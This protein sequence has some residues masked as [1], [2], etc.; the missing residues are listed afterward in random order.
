MHN[1]SMLYVRARL[2]ESDGPHYLAIVKALAQG[3]D[4]GDLR[5]GLP[6]PSQ[7]TLAR[8]LGLHFT[9]VT[10]AYGEAKRRGLISTEPG[11]GTVIAGSSRMSGR[12]RDA[13]VAKVVD[14]SAVWPPTLRIPLDLSAALT[15]LGGEGGV[16]LF[17][18]RTGR[19]ELAVTEPATHWLQPRF[20]AS[21]VG[22]VTVSAGT[23]GALL[24]L[25]RL[26]VGNGGILLTEAMT[27]PT[28]KALASMFDVKLRGVEMDAE[29]I[30]PESLDRHARKS[31]A[32]ALY[33]VPNSQNPTNGIMSLQRRQR[34][35]EVVLRHDLRVFED[36]VYGELMD[37]GL[38]P[39]AELVPSHAYYIA[40]L[41]K[42]LSPTLRVAYVI[43]PEE[44]AARDLESL[45]RSTM[46]LPAPIE[47]ALTI[48]LMQNGSAFRHIAK[49]RA[50]ARMR[51]AVA[52][53]ALGEFRHA[54]TVGP[55]FAWLSLPAQW[56]RASF[57]EGMRR[58]GVLLL[59]SDVFAVDG[60]AAPHCIRIATGSA[61]DQH[62]LRQ[63]FVA[64]AGLLA[65][66]EEL[67]ISGV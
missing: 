61:A 58:R 64:T 21:L 54:A 56:N 37:T 2:A 16:R 3:I 51:R 52:Q 48:Q 53:Q 67:A 43:A 34:I 62:E 47:E 33:C 42:C 65:S 59:P 46:L 27:W 12:Q 5:P 38:P 8:E 31:G 6:L 1:A 26:V 25:M 40:S 17:S 20:S 10:R 22:R 29:G 45:L 23:R 55:L 39:L 18:A 13:A 49:V 11:V 32:K 28:L 7:R 30:I 24:A 36:D 66:P 41:A 4:S 9:T 50:E 57:I 19:R 63:A 14:L 35:A 60:G 15:A 44:R